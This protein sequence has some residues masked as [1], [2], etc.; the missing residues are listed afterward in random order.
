MNLCL[1]ETLQQWALHNN[2]M[3]TAARVRRPKDKA[4]VEI[5]VKFVY[6]RVYATLRNLVFFSLKEL[7]IHIRSSFPYTTS[8]LSRKRPLPPGLF[9]P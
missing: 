2:L 8:A 7:N 9:Y 4:P 5:E 3:L 1:T 6:Q